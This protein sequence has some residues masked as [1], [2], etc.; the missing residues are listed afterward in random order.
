MIEHVCEKKLYEIC[1]LIIY[2]YEKKNNIHFSFILKST[3]KT[4][5]RDN[6][7]IDRSSRILLAASSELLVDNG[8]CQL[9]VRSYPTIKEFWAA[10]DCLE[11]GNHW[12]HVHHFRVNDNNP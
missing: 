4:N 10:D 6:Q 8:C 1:N 2:F 7:A 12:N 11:K 3:I 5:D 9:V